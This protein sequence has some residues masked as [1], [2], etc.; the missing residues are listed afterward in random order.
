MTIRPF[1]SLTSRIIPASGDVWPPEGF[2]VI[3][4]RSGSLETESGW[5]TFNEIGDSVTSDGT[6]LRI[7]Y[8]DGMTGGIGAGDIIPNPETLNVLEMWVR[9]IM[10]ISS[11]P[12]YYGHPGGT[13]KKLFFRFADG[14]PDFY[15]GVDGAGS[16]NLFFGLHTQGTISHPGG[17]NYST[18]AQCVRGVTYVCDVYAK[19]NSSGN[20]DGVIRL[21]VDGVEQ[22]FSTGTPADDPG[23][24]IEWE[25]GT[26]NIYNASWSPIWGG[27]GSEIGQE[28]PPAIPADIYVE[29][30][31][32]SIAAPS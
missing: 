1:G 15:L 32:L 27:A 13:N 9:V 3:K 24:N 18:A 19:A 14:Q 25:T 31:S 2:T 30:K 4:E 10:R 26:P 5:N 17:V 16:D 11:S 28:G 29:L 12:S 22:S 7:T 23:D 8:P 21:K 6:W 20:A